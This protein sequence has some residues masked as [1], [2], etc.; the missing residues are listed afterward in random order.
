MTPKKINPYETNKHN[1]LF[2]AEVNKVRYQLSLYHSKLGLCDPKELH[3]SRH[4]AER[5]IE[6]GLQKEIQ[7]IFVIAK[8]FME[9]V[10]N[11]TTFCERTYQ[12]DLRG[13]KVVF[14]I[15]LGKESG[16]REAIVM[17]AFT[18]NDDYNCDEKIILK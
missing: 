4:L 13:L 7:F 6:R 12:V 5:L 17:T 16:R 10:F 15:T 9:E 8:F 3:F 2:N 18:S 11:G 1:P 14:L